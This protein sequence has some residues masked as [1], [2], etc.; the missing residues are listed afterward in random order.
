MTPEGIKP[1]ELRL[2][3][4]AASPALTS[5]ILRAVKLGELTQQVLL[6]SVESGDVHSSEYEITIESHGP[7]AELSEKEIQRIREQG[8]TDE[9]LQWAANFYNLGQVLGLPPAK[10]VEIN[11]GLPRT[12]ASKWV[13]RAREKGLLAD[14]IVGERTPESV[15]TTYETPV[16]KAAND[17]TTAEV[18]DDALAELQK[19]I[20]TKNNGND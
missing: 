16:D 13:R 14:T 8:P 3:S 9:S 1:V 5:T 15:Y 4:D 12:T 6:K 10:Q 17:K 18:Y 7:V 11:L 20:G 19:H 2:R